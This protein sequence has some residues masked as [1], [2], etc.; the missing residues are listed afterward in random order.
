MSRACIPSVTWPGPG[1]PGLAL[2]CLPKPAAATPRAGLR[3]CLAAM[4]AFLFYFN[5]FAWAAPLFVVM[6]LLTPY[7]LVFDHTRYREGLD[8]GYACAG[9]A[10]PFPPRSQRPNLAVPQEKSAARLQHALG[11]DQFRPVLQGA[12]HR[13]G[14]SAPFRTAGRVCCQPPELPCERRRG[15]AVSQILHLRGLLAPG[16]F[17]C[18]MTCPT[19]LKS[20]ER[21]GRVPAGSELPSSNIPGYH[22]ALPH[23]P[24]LQICFQDCQLLH[25]HHWLV[26]VPHRCGGYA[27]CAV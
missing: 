21:E 17:W 1:L 18:L 7:V 8:P 27:G 26:H 22:H 14:E 9:L 16:V 15:L 19:W 11:Q 24:G 23:Q 10:I 13:L 5:T 4:R 6:L 25:T 20:L 3:G 2:A 12:H